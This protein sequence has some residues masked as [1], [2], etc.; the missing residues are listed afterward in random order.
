MATVKDIWKIYQTSRGWHSSFGTLVLT[1]APNADYTVRKF[2]VYESA[3]H[4]TK[5][6]AVKYAER[7]GLMGKNR[8]EIIYE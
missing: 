7:G 5:R 3:R 8:G 1:P 2:N 4:D 6:Q